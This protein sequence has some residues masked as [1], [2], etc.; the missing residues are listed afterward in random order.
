M[1][2]RTDAPWGIARISSKD[3]LHGPDFDAL[4]FTYRYDS[5]AGANSD[6]YILGA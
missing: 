3:Q 4:N 1:F 6:V 2:C 5:S